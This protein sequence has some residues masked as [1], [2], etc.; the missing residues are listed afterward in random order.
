MV[1]S[2]PTA[3]AIFRPGRCEPQSTVG[4]CWFVPTTLDGGQGR[5]LPLP[6]WPG[7]VVAVPAGAAG[8]R[9]ENGS[10]VATSPGVIF[11]SHA[12]RT[13]V[14]QGSPAEGLASWTAL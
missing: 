1:P 5:L 13:S 10:T 3:G 11:T 9:D 4:G 6:N 8:T 2:A 7:Q 14:C 12:P